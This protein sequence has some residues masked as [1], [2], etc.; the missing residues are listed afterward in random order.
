MTCRMNVIQGNQ[1]IIVHNLHVIMNVS[2]LVN[3]IHFV[4]L[5]NKTHSLVFHAVLHAIL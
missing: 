5:Y 4:L 2:I 3:I 1:Y